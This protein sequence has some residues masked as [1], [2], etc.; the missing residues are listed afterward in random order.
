MLELLAGVRP[1]SK[2][3]AAIRIE[4]VVAIRQLPA[5]IQA[6][7]VSTTP[8]AA[9]YNALLKDV[10]TISDALAAFALAIQQR[11]IR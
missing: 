3:K 10:K 11:D 6:V 7:S 9:Q 4:D 8:T 5:K 1:G 2:N